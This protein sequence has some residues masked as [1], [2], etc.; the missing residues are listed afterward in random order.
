MM[1]IPNMAS[2]DEDIVMVEVCATLFAGETT[3]KEFNVNLT[4]SDNKGK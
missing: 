3:E 1:S 2:I 4:T